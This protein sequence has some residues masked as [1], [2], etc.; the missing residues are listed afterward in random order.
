MSDFIPLSVP[1]IRGNEWLYIKQCLDT[2]W[3]SSVGSFVDRFEKEIKDYTGAKHAVAC[4]NGT[5]ALHI[6]M[7]VAGVMPD[8]EVLLPT[9]TFIAPVNA[10]NYLNAHPVFMDCDE[11]YN[12]DC[13]KTIEFIKKETV[14]RDGFS[15][16]RKT[17]R[18]ISAIIPVHVFG[19]A[20]WLDDLLHVCGERRI[21]LI[22]D[23]TE[24]LG[25]YYTRGARTG[26]H[27]GTI[28]DIGCYSFNGNKIITTGGGG[29]IVTDNDE[30][31]RKAK[32]LTTQAKDDDVYFIHHEIGYN[33]RMTNLQA[34]MG[35]AQLE[36]LPEY[37]RLKK[38]H[39]KKYAEHFLAMK[40]I[41]LR[42]VPDYSDNNHW[43]YALQTNG[44]LSGENRDRLIQGMK[45]NN[46]QARPVWHLNHLQKPYVDC[47][48]FR[49]ERAYRMIETTVNI[50]C[51]VGLSD[52]DI[53]RV[54]DTIKAIG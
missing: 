36:M 39:F 52:G 48:S 19:N 50:P 17:N 44:G 29:M 46:I 42:A 8:D 45:K 43:M 20:V 28:G 41:S 22:E 15:F 5:S 9:L 38:E 24:S 34:A 25:S 13:E 35:V 10:V 7:K 49:I 27:T 3:V 26:R 32:Y 11:Y 40:G 18:R 14:F 2:G 54:A 12:L 1:E 53:Q 30:Y 37:I 6:S 4:M 47:Q 33:Y 31:A 16:S 23:A 51:S 21:K